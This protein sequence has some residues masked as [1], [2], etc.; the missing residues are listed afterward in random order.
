ME[1]TPLIVLDTNVLVSGLCRRENSASYQILQH[2]QKGKIP[3]AISYKLFLE[4]E[5]VLKREKILTLI[6]ATSE[7]VSMILDALVAIAHRSE[8]FYLWRPNLT[9]ENDNFVLET[10]ITTGAAIVTKNIKDFQEGEL[11]FPELTVLTPSQFCKL[12]L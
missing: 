2:I 8:V 10:A 6:K 9:D 4:Y 3:L 11:I 1:T 5:S 12:Y 7:E